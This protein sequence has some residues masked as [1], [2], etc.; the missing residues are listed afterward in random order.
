[1]GRFPGS[2]GTNHPAYAAIVR[3]VDDGHT[4]VKL[5]GVYHES[6]IGP[7]SYSYRATVGAAFA[8]AAPERMLWGSDW[9]HPT[10]SRGEVPMRPTTTAMLDASSHRRCYAS[11]TESESSSRARTTEMVYRF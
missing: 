3:L 1:M 6:P 4:W 9:P 2:T 10:A 7:P 8:Q 5:S 11:K